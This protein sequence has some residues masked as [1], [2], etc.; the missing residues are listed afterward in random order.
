ISLVLKLNSDIS[1][2]KDEL[3]KYLGTIK[4]ED[5]IKSK[6][7]EEIFTN[8]LSH[9]NPN[10]RIYFLNFNYTQTPELYFNLLGQ[11]TPLINYI[12]GKLG[13]EINNPII[14]GYG[15]ETDI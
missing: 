2:I 8:D 14:F 5:S 6:S 3:I 9:S 12:H 4:I 11:R 7:I 13:D 10:S 1:K 15:D